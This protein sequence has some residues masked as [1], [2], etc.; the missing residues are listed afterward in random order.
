MDEQYKINDLIV[1]AVKLPNP[2][3]V[4]VEITREFVFL[5]VG[6]RDW[7]W[8]RKTGRLFGSGVGLCGSTVKGEGEKTVCETS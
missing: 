8:D 3:P 7:Q 2:C 1:G 5:Y 4:R 6:Q